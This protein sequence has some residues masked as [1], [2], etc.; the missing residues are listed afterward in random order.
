MCRFAIAGE[1]RPARR[2]RRSVAGPKRLPDDRLVGRTSD[3]RSADG[4]EP[5]FVGAGMRELISL[6]HERGHEASWQAGTY[7]VSAA[8]GTRLR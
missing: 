6:A 4:D 3:S 7:E 1:V 5:D 8:A 2:H